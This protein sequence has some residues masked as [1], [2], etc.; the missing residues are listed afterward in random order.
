MMQFNGLFRFARNWFWLFVVGFQLAVTA[1]ESPWRQVE[2]IGASASAGFVLS[3]PFGGTNTTRCKLHYYLDAAI[4]APHAPVKNLASAMFFLS[5][6]ATAEQQIQ[7]V[8][9]HPPSLVVAVDFL[10][11]F[12]YGNVGNDAQRAQ[13]FEKGLKLLEQIPCPLVVG[14][15]PDVSS[16]T[17]LG[18]LI[19]AMVP[20]AAARN[21]A[22][23]RLRE[24][25]AAHAQ[26]SLM[27]LAESVKTAT[28]D[29]PLTWHGQVFPAEKNAEVTQDDR[30]HP[31]PW[32]ASLLALGILDA[33]VVQN[34]NFPAA[35]IRWS[36]QE[37][38]RRGYDAAK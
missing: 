3:E 23:K 4:A 20:S 18:I 13:H 12:C 11:W 2:V 8:T 34:P 9:N 19:P 32:G 21:A 29:K 38:F 33:L 36:P 15:I 10:F 26:V 5:P 22:N 28:S 6:D 16:A 7:A 1:A 17:N 37:V 14:D 25:V 35:D 30:L 31:T 24:W 27:P